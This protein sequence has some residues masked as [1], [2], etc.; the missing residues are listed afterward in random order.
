MKLFITT[1]IAVV[2]AMQAKAQTNTNFTYDAAGFRIKRNTPPPP[3]GGAN[4]PPCAGR[5]FMHAYPNPATTTT[6]LIIDEKLAG[7]AMLVQ[8]I[9]VDGRVVKSFNTTTT[10]HEINVANLVNGVYFIHIITNKANLQYIFN[11]ID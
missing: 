8:M 3:C 4:Q 1:I 9:S 7:E 10:Q 2:F 6:T 11:K 5:L